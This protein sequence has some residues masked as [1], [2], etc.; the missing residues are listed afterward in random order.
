MNKLENKLKNK[1]N[2]PIVLF[3]IVLINYL[4]LFINNAFT[5]ESH[6]VSAIIMLV[7]F[8]IEICLLIYMFFKNKSD[9]KIEKRNMI[10]LTIIFGILCIVQL[11]NFLQK[12]FYIMD[13]FNIGCTCI[14][15]FMLYITLYDL[16]ISEKKICR[17]F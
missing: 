8:L 2:L 7:F 16:K 6:S 9:I 17:I 4:P 14:N 13:I 12:N 5:K 11:K 15:I 10:L 1:D 3:V